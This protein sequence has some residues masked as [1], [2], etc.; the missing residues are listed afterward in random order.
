MIMQFSYCL[1]LQYSSAQHYS[2]FLLV[3]SF[4]LPS[5]CLNFIVISLDI[6]KGAVLKR[7]LKFSSSASGGTIR[8]LDHAV[9]ARVT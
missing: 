7:L 4:L 6:H 9:L 5:A 3:L 8:Q 1:S 2:L